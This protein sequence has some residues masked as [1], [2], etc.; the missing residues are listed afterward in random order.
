MTVNSQLTFIK[1][2]CPWKI[3]GSMRLKMMDKSKHVLT[4]KTKLALFTTLIIPLFGNILYVGIN[5]TDSYSLPKLQNSALLRILNCDFRTHI[6]EMH[7]QLKLDDIV[8]QHNKHVDCQVDG[9]DDRYVQL[10]KRGFLDGKQGLIISIIM[11]WGV[12][13]RYLYLKEKRSST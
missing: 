2:Y 5:Q 7:L 13:L 12:F 9:L 1:S 6:Y 3:Q 11:A 8:I 4:E 10:E